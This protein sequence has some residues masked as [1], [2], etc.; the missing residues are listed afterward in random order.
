MRAGLRRFWPLAVLCGH[1]SVTCGPDTRGIPIRNGLDVHAMHDWQ[2][3]WG[4]CHGPVPM[5][6]R[7]PRRPYAGGSPTP[8]PP[9]HTKPYPHT[10]T[11]LL[12]KTDFN[13]AKTCGHGA[14]VLYPTSHHTTAWQSLLPLPAPVWALR[15]C[16]HLLYST[17]WA[18]PS[19]M[20]GHIPVTT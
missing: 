16:S 14:L 15:T 9:S 11:E 6:C 7:P 10:D 20:P 12:K 18:A 19:G 3:S 5:H 8:G 13:P 2:A 4:R 17:V 1:T